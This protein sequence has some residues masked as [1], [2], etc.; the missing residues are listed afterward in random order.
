MPERLARD[1]ETGHRPRAGLTHMPVCH[2]H[3]GQHAGGG[4]RQQHAR[5]QVHRTTT[6]TVPSQAGCAG[7][8]PDERATQPS[9]QP[10]TR[11]HDMTIP[12]RK[13]VVA[14]GVVGWQLPP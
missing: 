4:Q 8:Q 12:L 5:R 1:E 2:Y 11:I 14:A 10:E 13:P 3:T 9:E 6:E 7:E